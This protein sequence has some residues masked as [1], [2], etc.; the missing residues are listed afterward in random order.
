MRTARKRATAAVSVL[1]VAL[2]L[3]VLIETIVVGGE[4]GFLLGALLLAAGFLRIV[5]ARAA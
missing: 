2:G 5:L 1:L 4:L 3:A